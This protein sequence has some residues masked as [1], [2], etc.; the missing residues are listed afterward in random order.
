MRKATNG[1]FTAVLD[2]AKEH[3]L[4]SVGTV[5]CAAAS[6]LAKTYRDDRMRQLA[7]EYPQYG[8]EHNMGYPTAEHI[9]A[10][11]RFGY[12]PY[13]RKSFHPKE[14]EPTLF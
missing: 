5:L 11:K 1:V 8:W 13:H 2:A 10:I 7:R 14:L 12:T 3:K 9:E 6:V 4:L